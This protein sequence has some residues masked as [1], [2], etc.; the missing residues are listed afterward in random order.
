LRESGTIES[1]A[2]MVILLHPITEPDG[3][4]DERIVEAIVAKNR[5]GPVGTARVLFQPKFVRFIEEM[6]PIGAFDPPRHSKERSNPAA[7]PQADTGDLPGME[8]DEPGV[9]YD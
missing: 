7:P 8:R 4:N 5:N 1:D 6:P 2:D 3:A 9:D